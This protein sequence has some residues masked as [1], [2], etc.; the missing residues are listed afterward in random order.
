M[1]PAKVDPAAAEPISWT[2]VPIGNEN[3][4]VAGQLIPAGLLVIVPE[5]LPVR[6]TARLA[7]RVSVSDSVWSP[8]GDFESAIEVNP[9]GVMFPVPSTS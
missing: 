3:E 9:C 5:P 1:M 2:E 7:S 8:R 6:V 4:Q